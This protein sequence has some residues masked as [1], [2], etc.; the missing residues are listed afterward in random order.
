MGQIKVDTAAFAATHDRPPNEKQPALWTFSIQEKDIC[1][2]GTY[3][4]AR[5]TARRY[6]CSHGMC[7]GTITLIDCTGAPPGH[8]VQ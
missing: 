3:A 4:E 1:F 8:H 7:E 5:E 6:A 2:W